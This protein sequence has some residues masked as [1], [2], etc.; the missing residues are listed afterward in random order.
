MNARVLRRHGAALLCA[1]GLGVL[2]YQIVFLFRSGDSDY[3]DHLS[4]A[5]RMSAP[6]MLS[7]L[8]R[9]RDYLWHIFVHLA[10]DAGVRNIWSAA[11]LV[12]ALADA[13]AYLLVYGGWNRLL[14]GDKPRRWL[15]ALTVLS[16]FLASS[17]T[18]PGRTFYVGRGAVNTWQN[19]T[20]IMVR[21]F[22]AAVFYMTVD[23][24][25]RRRGVRQGADRF[26]FTGGF[27]AQFEQPVY[28]RA[29]VVLYP[30]C[31]ALSA[32]AKPSFLQVFA[33]AILILLAIDVIRTRGMLLPFCLKL[34]LA[35]L[36]A[37]LLLLRQFGVFFGAGLS[38]TAL[39]AEAGRAP[40]LYAGST[41]GVS[42]YYLENGWT[43]LV[44]FLQLTWYHLK[45][46]L[47][48]CAFPLAVALAAPRRAWHDAGFRLGLL[49]VAAGLLEAMFLHETGTRSWHGNFTWGLYVGCW[50]L[51]TAAAGPFAALWSDRG[52]VGR[53]A[54]WVCTA[55]LAWHLACG[56]SYIGSI[57]RT[58]AY[59][60]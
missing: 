52:A 19:P 47:L 9:G 32:M 23:I 44:P 56:L 12:T 2:V 39:A 34:A 49:C 45:T 11:A 40:V 28:T 24:Y 4:W 20:N 50:L 54:R 10:V 29:Q 5:M 7:E 35:F 22:A 51:W 43:G 30:L 6:E 15:L 18:M 14:P 3:V 58:G 25:D 57:M 17:L 8:L 13:L 21:P 1:A 60:F 36:P 38:V 42:V 33:P 53:W 16:A 59:Y 41:A 48:P 55:L 46:A 31:L 26:L 37:G 27:W